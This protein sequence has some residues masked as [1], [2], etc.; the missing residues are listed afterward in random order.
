[1]Q[2]NNNFNDINRLQNNAVPAWACAEH[3]EQCVGLDKLWGFSSQVI[4][5]KKHPLRKKLAQKLYKLASEIDFT[6]D[7]PNPN[8]GYVKA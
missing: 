3:Y 5:V 8:F 1:M 4:P 6:E 2:W 7:T